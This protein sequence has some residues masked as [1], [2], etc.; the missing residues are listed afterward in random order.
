MKLRTL[1]AACAALSTL[2]FATAGF[3]ADQVTAKLTAPVAQKIKVVAGGAVF[4][5]EGDTCIAAATSSQ[6]YSEEGCKSLAA[7]VG[8]V[9][10]FESRKAFDAD[11]LTACNKVAK[12]GSTELAKQ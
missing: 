9:A 3:A 12:G 2:S 7:K 8:T 11:R 10:S 4:N 6:T 5:C 1:M